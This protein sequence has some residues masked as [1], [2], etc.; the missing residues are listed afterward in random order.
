MKLFTSGTNPE[1]TGG[2]Y[3]DKAGTYHFVINEQSTG[4][5]GNG[6]VLRNVVEV[7]AG[8]HSDQVGKQVGYDL[9]L[10]EGSQY[11]EDNANALLRFGCA[12]GIY[13]KAQW[14]ADLKA[15]S[16][17]DVPIDN[18]AGLQ[19][20]GKVEMKP[21]KTDKSKSW[22]RVVRIYAVGD[23]EAQ[24]VPVSHDH[25]SVFNGKLP[26]SAG[27]FRGGQP[28]GNASPATQAAQSTTGGIDDLF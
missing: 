26:M 12:L 18:A 15:G 24:G 4:A 2:K 8:E 20:V 13:S 27:G 6:Q 25:L 1:G 19:F 9:F 22:A 17:A 28:G 16:A 11:P 21:D 7:L 14:D 10:P 3:V 23:D 5:A